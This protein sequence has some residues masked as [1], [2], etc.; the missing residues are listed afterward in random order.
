MDFDWSSLG[1]PPSGGEETDP[2][3]IFGSLQ[4][5]ESGINDLWLGQGDALRDWHAN[6]HKDDVAIILNTGAGKTLVGLLAA[7]SLV[8]ETRGRV[9]YVCASLQLVEQTASKARS[10]GLEA[11]T[12]VGGSGF[13]DT[14]YQEGRAPCLT[15]YQ[16]LFNGLT[17]RWDDVHCIIFDDAHAATNIIRAQFTL[18]V[19]REPH[20]GVHEAV[21][22]ALSEHLRATGSD[23]AYRQTME[24]G[25]AQ[26]RWFVPP[27]AI[28][29]NVGALN[30]ALLDARL[31]QD[32]SQ[33]FPWGY[34]RDKIHLCAVF[35]SARTVW[36]TPPVVPVRTL[37]Y[38]RAGVRRIYLSATLA[39]E[40]AFLR[41]FG[42]VPD[43]VVAPST[44]AGNCERMIL[45]PIAVPGVEDDVAIAKEVI[46]PRKTLILVPTHRDGRTWDEC[47]TPELGA[48]T[49]TQVEEFKQADP[50]ATLRLVA[51]Y[52]GV[53]L[54]GDTCRT[55]V[56]HGLPSGLG[57][58]E[59]FMW[60]GLGV[61]NVLRSTVA[62]R[63]VQSF[64]RISRGMADHGVVVL[65]GGKLVDWIMTPANR[66]ALPAF[67]RRQTEVGLE[68]SKAASPEQLALLVQ[69]CM[70]QHPGWRDH[71]SRAMAGAD[72]QADATSDTLLSNAA[73]VEAEFGRFLWNEDFERAVRAL[74]S[75]RDTLFAASKG[76]GGWYLLWM[77]YLSDILGDHDT[78]VD[79][80]R[81]A[82]RAEKVLPIVPSEV[83]AE[84]PLDADAAQIEEIANYMLG[85]GDVLARFD[86]EVAALE[87]GS[88]P[89][90]EEATRCLGSFLGLDSSRPDNDVGT[91]PDVLWFV[92]G[93]P[94]WSLELKTGRNT[95]ASYAKKH[96][97]QA[98]NHLQW[99]RDNKNADSIILAII[100]PVVPADRRANPPNDLMVMS[101]QALVDLRDRARVALETVAASRL[102]LLVRD[103]IRRVFGDAG[104]LWS[105]LS[106]NLPGVPLRTIEVEP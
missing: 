18:S 49:A 25:D 8:N 99:V 4:L 78:A 12:Y 71:Y 39:A 44:P 73:Q 74:H 95:T 40:D 35:I 98:V 56:I 50:P 16:A 30:Q 62:S 43:H 80:Y 53:D 27:F 22:A 14:R 64:G 82:R 76:L 17:R 21:G 90:V 19:D 68:L 24:A 88:V 75:G 84:E 10:Y 61:F 77:G 105:N 81:Q 58:L 106:A 72:D 83:C 7:Q 54:P 20:L 15:T 34:L 13:S 59:R 103:E 47:I 93:Q 52:D 32:Q 96:V 6:R 37:P 57:P 51:R 70:D 91:G 31:H 41:T 69:Q 26:A 87:E 1:P 46:A 67:L 28:R 36:F 48:D 79:L 97:A 2:I 29:R 102:P 101:P 5:Q 85:S 11:T 38:F 86:R 33:M 100:G 23:L 9:A 45:F 65:T 94:A 55:M 60:E 104:L 89:Q 66:Q 3:K 42:K 63:I 92:P